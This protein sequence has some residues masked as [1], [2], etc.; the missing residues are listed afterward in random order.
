MLPPGWTPL[1]RAASIADLLSQLSSVAS[2]FLACRGESRHYQ[3]HVSSLGRELTGPDPRALLTTEAALIAE[4]R[5][6][7]YGIASPQ[8]VTLMRTV[9]GT[10]WIMQHHGA[11]TR[12]LDWT[13]SIWVGAYMA[14]IEYLDK[15]GFVWFFSP[16][17]L[18]ARIP[19]PARDLVRAVTSA[20]TAAEYRGLLESAPPFIDIVA[21]SGS[22]QRMNS[23]QSVATIANPVNADHMVVI[24]ELARGQD[25][26]RVL[27]V[28]AE[29]KRPLG[30]QLLSMN[31]T[32]KSLFPG[33]DGVGQSIKEMVAWQPSISVMD[34]A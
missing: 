34:E 10:M 25:W 15:D 27:M 4:F 30:Q 14:C 24:G 11:P 8:E 18:Q 33:L 26:A 16:G 1:P 29:L 22:T 20:Q 28:P 9:G 17:A 12:M 21:R 19:E 2:D 13:R 5:D 31:I 3:D 7:A 23:Q 32:G 6:A